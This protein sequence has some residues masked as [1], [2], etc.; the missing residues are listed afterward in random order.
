M[1]VSRLP[2]TDSTILFRYLLIGRV[3]R[4]VY[5]SLTRIGF[6]I[7][8]FGPAE[9]LFLEEVLNPTVKKS[10]LVTISTIILPSVLKISFLSDHSY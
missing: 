5:N 4:R 2:K 10:V 8:G 9:I 7:R 3:S 6:G 1:I